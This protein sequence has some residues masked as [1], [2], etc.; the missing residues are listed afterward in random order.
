[1][2]GRAGNL[3]AAR[4]D[5]ACSVGNQ[6]THEP[7]F[8]AELWQQENRDITPE[9]LRR[10]FG[11]SRGCAQPLEPRESYCYQTK[12]KIDFSTFFVIIQILVEKAA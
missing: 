5:Q 4:I 10:D 9:L 7:V 2:F 3:T 1:M 6:I 12:Q 11:P 8:Q